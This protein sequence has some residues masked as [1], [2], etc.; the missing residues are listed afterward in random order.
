MSKIQLYS[1]A[2][3]NGQKVSVCLEEMKI[4]YDAHTI[5]IRK[6]MQFSDEFVHLNPNS[7][8]PAIVDPTGPNSAPI[9]V[10]ESGA[11]L[12]YLAEKTNKFLPEDKSSR[13]EAMQWLF[14][15]MASIGPMF[16]QFGHFFVFAK[17]NC[18]DPYPV[19]RYSKEAK[20]LLQVME[21]RLSSRDYILDYGYSICDMAT[22]PWVLAL[23]DFYHA[24]EELG[25]SDFPQ[26]TNWLNMCL[27]RSA[28]QTGL[29]I[30]PFD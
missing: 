16:G 26:V 2:T 11:I 19:T 23:N 9:T 5:D 10:F 27:A 25:L 20:R 24:N 8:I 7:K 30:C 18:K 22:F 15:Q 29:K 4:P 21:T 1:L 6:N 28:V 17:E 12:W 3:P 14:F 13:C